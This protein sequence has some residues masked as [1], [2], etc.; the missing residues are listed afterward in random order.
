MYR[1]IDLR[2]KLPKHPTRRWKKR[3]TASYIVVHCTASDTQDPFITARYHISKKCHISPGK[4]CPGL[5]Y[6]DY[7]TK[8]G[9]VFHCNDYQDITWHAGLY[10]KRSIGVV[11]AFRGQIGQTPTDAQYLAL[12]QHLVILCLYLKI[13]P[14]N[15]IGHREVPGMFRILGNGSK[16][17]RK[18]CPG[19]GVHLDELRKDIT[20]RLQRRLAAEG[21]YSGRIDGLW[22]RKSRAAL[23]AFDPQKAWRR[24][25]AFV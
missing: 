3:D 5:C 6:S 18:T 7:V 9:T 20:L 8:D 21:L 14:K 24:L 11:M 1:L 16:R 10:N 19:M 15:V 13:P 12:K 2:A 4:G 25:N 23:R 17:Y 22:G